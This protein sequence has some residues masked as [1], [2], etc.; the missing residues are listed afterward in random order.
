M[1]VLFLHFVPSKS[2]CCEYFDCL[3]LQPALANAPMHSSNLHSL[4]SAHSIEEI[5]S[6]MVSLSI[7]SQL[8]IHWWLT[9]LV[10]L[11]QSHS[12]TEG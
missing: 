10:K 9:P 4:D 12:M 5:S 11:F 1:I 6:Q 7:R 8:L 2:Q 3:S